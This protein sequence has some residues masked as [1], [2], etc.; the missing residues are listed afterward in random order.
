MGH[1]LFC[2]QE[3]VPKGQPEPMA[4]WPPLSCV[5]LCQSVLPPQEAH[6]H[7]GF[8]SCCSLSSG[9]PPWKEFLPR[10]Q[11]GTNAVPF[12]SV[13]SLYSHTSEI[14]HV[15]FLKPQQIQTPNQVLPHSV[16]QSSVLNC[17]STFS[18]KPDFPQSLFQVHTQ[19]K[20]SVLLSKPG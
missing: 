7:R 5:C 15:R 3:I 6:S 11:E 4:S 16:L 2:F 18:L 13:S 19:N 12:T 9:H 10:T 1:S 8:L 17:G 14:Q 20:E